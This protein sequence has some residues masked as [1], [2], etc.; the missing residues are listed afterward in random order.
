MKISRNT[1]THKNQRNMTPSKEHNNFP[2][3]SPKE[4][5]IPNLPDK[6]FKIAVFRKLGEWERKQERQISRKISKTIQ[7]Q[8]KF[9]R[10]KEIILKILS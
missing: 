3:T 8:N 2:V 5:K 10:E 9:N 7:D 1:H 4:M 6:E